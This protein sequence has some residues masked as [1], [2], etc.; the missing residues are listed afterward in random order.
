MSY[1]QSR[2]SN[3]TTE[4]NQLADNMEQHGSVTEE[5][6]FYIV[7]GVSLMCYVITLFGIAYL[8][9]TMKT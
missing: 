6:L 2:K 9:G 5:A 8:A 3:Q 7:E 1:G 4:R